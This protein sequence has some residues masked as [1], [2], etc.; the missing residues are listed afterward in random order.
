MTST[1]RYPG[2]RA[3]QGDE[4]ILCVPRESELPDLVVSNRQRPEFETVEWFGR[5]LGEIARGARTEL[6]SAAVDYTS[7]YARVDRKPQV[8]R[9]LIITGHQAELFHPGVWLKNFFAARLAKKCDG[10]ALNLIIDSDLCRGTAIRVPTGTVS[11]VHSEM[12][13]YDKALAEMPFEERAIADLAQWES[14][15][16]R[17]VDVLH[18]RVTNPL[19]ESWWPTVVSA[20]RRQANLG[21]ALSQARHQCELSWGAQTLELPQSRV[22]QSEA[23]R[24]FAL[25]L[26]TGAAEFR[27][28]H[29]HALADYRAAHKLKN[30]AQPM[31]NLIAKECWVETPF[32]LWSESNPQ[33]RGVFVKSTPEELTISDLRQHS[34]Q[35]PWDAVQAVEKLAAWEKQGVKLRTRALATTL[36]ARLLLADVFIH[37]IGGAKY[38]QVTDHICELFFGLTVRKYAT[39]SGTLRLPLAGQNPPIESES[40]LRQQLWDLR[41]HPERF[42][43]FLPSKASD[44]GKVELAIA[45]KHRWIHTPKTPSNAAERH[46]AIQRT[47]Q[48]LLSFLSKRRVGLERALVQAKLSAN[49]MQLRNSR[50]YAYC[51][52]S[53]D[54]LREFFQV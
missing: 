41:F 39:V 40:S 26:F 7:G 4:E 38:D 31:P 10:T 3:P 52:F 51:L 33:R 22:C 32:W 16:A 9:P 34:L 2:F 35:L 13:P 50:E 12:V 19:V 5:S 46:Q 24:L 45:E 47:N 30:H 53:E 25:K 27:E 15:G 21:L 8:D 18:Q 48:L 29:N 37:G 54:R 28:A 44:A 17:V 49:A 1:G 23:F 20:S 42:C 43:S 6:L 11:D 14:F 36:F